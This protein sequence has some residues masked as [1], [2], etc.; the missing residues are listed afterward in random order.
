[1]TMKPSR[2]GDLRK[3][4]DQECVPA[5]REKQKVASKDHEAALGPIDQK[6]KPTRQVKSIHP[7]PVTSAKER[8][9]V[10]GAKEKEKQR[11]RATRERPTKALRKGNQKDS[12]KSAS[13]T[14]D[15]AN[16]SPGAYEATTPDW[17]EWHEDSYFADQRSKMELRRI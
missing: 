6:G 10:A 11:T 9:K 4:E 14:L 5:H 2:K 7:I 15:Q 1:M 13:S 12:A 16:A 3:E 8:T 17:D